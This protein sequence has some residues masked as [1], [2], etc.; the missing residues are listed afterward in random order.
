MRGY[1]ENVKSPA[2]CFGRSKITP[3]HYSRSFT[4]FSNPLSDFFVN[5]SGARRR[6]TNKA[7]DT[8]AVAD[9]FSRAV[10]VTEK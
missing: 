6:A 1:Y 10:N 4:V 7:I 3:P 5:M 8:T 2:N 9:L